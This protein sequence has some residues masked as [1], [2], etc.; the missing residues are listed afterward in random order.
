MRIALPLLAFI[1]VSRSTRPKCWL[2][3]RMP[4]YRPDTTRVERMPIQRPDMRTIERMPV[5]RMRCDSHA[6]RA[7]RDTTG[8]RCE[9]SHAS[10][11]QCR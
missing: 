3:D 9:I 7:P 1:A 11:F 2:S 4:V 10:P 8:G 5:A 6:E